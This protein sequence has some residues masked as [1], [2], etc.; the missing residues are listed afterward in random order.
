MGG[1]RQYAVALLKILARDTDNKYFVYHEVDDPEVMGVLQNN[2]QITL[3]KRGKS[4]VPVSITRRI[5]GKPHDRLALER[6][7]KKYHIDIAHCPYQYLPAA[8]NVKSICTMHDV[9]E[10]HFPEYFTAEDRAHR[11]VN[12]LSYIKNA[13]KIVVSY[14]HVKHDLVKYFNTPPTKVDVCLL[15]MDNLWLDKYTAADIAPLDDLNLPERFLFYPANTW[16]H[17]NHHKLL[18]ALNNLV[19]NGY[20]DIKIVFTGH[21]TD[22]FKD[23]LKPYIAENNL[24]HNALFIGIVE[25][26]TLY[27]LYQ[28]CIGVV[29]PT[30][31]EAGSFPLMEALLLAVPV[32]CSNVTSLP[33]TIGDDD[34]VFNP[35][36]INSITQKVKQLWIDEA[37]RQKSISNSYGQ[38]NKLRN[39]HA[40][41]K[42]KAIYAGC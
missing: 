3:V 36:D 13:D 19:N 30:L 42:M 35:L 4:M 24:E 27:N 16:Q 23:K 10:I 34:F 26:I 29:V 2:P 31:Y 39:T 1:L 6:I 32:I 8:D 11:A 12:Y 9:Q 18:E 40:L 20:P 25:E 38:A 14:Q 17:K 28:K 7:C 15:E 22:Y 21:Q 33:E 5:T 37:F 41:D